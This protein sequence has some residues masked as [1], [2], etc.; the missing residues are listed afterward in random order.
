MDYTG[1][2]IAD[3]ARDVMALVR[4]LHNDDS[5]GAGAVIS[6]MEERQLQA[7]YVR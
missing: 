4:A 5:D 7:V 6:G 2:E 3:A 1:D